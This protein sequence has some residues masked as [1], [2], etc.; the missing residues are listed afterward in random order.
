MHATTS[1]NDKNDDHELIEQEQNLKFYISI[2]ILISFKLIKEKIYTSNLIP[3][4]IRV[5][6]SVRRKNKHTTPDDRNVHNYSDE[7]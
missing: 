6:P 5:K 2:Y 1:E 3:S 4:V 7:R